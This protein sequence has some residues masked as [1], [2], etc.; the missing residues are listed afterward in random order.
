M[1]LTKAAGDPA[2]RAVGVIML[3]A[4]E[5]DLESQHVLSNTTDQ[6]NR[7]KSFQDFHR[8]LVAIKDRE[9]QV[10]LKL[11]LMLDTWE[12]ERAKAST[13]GCPPL[14]EDMSNAAEPHEA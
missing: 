9:A 11:G 8:D 14:G 5:P 3:P 6:D 10:V 4:D 13:E 2:Y 12:A 7:L 1:S